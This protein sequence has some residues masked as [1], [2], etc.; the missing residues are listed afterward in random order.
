MK[1]KR[2]GIAAGGLA[3]LLLVGAAFFAWETRGLEPSPCTEVNTIDGVWT[4]V[5]PESVTPE[6]LTLEFCNTTQ[7][8]DLF[9][10][11]SYC[12]EV[13]KFGRWYTYLNQP[14]GPSI[15]FRIPTASE[16]QA[17]YVEGRDYDPANV[18]WWARTP[19]NEKHYDWAVYCGALPPGQYRIVVDVLSDFDIPIRE[20]SP[21][22]YLAAPFSIP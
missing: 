8:R 1:G 11:V 17:G 6:S 2:S 12:I 3:L 9:Y 14:D 20:D 5:K 4:Q 15:G 22:Y 13:K 16:L 10:G 19:P 18:L 7:R 21:V